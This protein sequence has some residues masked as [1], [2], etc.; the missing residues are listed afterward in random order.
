MR[1]A[2]RVVVALLLAPGICEGTA[3]AGYVDGVDDYQRGDYAAAYREFL[4]AAEQGDGNAAHA[5]GLMYLTGRGVAQ[6]N[7]QAIQWYRE[8][9]E[10]GV[11]VAPPSGDRR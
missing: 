2:R 4:S 6:D 11:G 8:A 5:L 3:S 9:A 7:A 10:L 1:I